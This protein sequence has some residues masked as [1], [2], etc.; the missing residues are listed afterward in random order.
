MCGDDGW[1]NGVLS[2]RACIN[3]CQFY[4]QADR[5]LTHQYMGG[6]HPDEQRLPFPVLAALP[7]ICDMLSSLIPPL[8]GALTPLTVALYTTVLCI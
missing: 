8:F 7:K 6:S 3:V 2:G 5:A 1:G 4:T